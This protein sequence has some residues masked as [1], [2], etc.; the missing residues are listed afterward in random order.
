MMVFLKPSPLLVKLNDTLRR[1]VV[2]DSLMA[3]R[4]LVLSG[5]EKLRCSTTAG[6]RLLALDSE[7][8]PRNGVNAEPDL[9]IVSFSSTSVGAI[10][11][12]NSFG[13]DDEGLFREGA[14]EFLEP[15]SLSVKLNDTL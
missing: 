8:E 11:S 1:C 7:I 9:S 2:R 13:N 6:G 12:H 4:M 10:I 15:P 5:H 14:I 3:G